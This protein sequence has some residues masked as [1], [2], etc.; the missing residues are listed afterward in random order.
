MT[1]DT[2]ATDLC[3]AQTIAPGDELRTVVSLEDGT[4]VS[5]DSGQRV[6]FPNLSPTELGLGDGDSIGLQF[7]VRKPIYGT[8]DSIDSV[9]V[10]DVE[11]IAPEAVAGD[12]TDDRS[13]EEDSSS[14]SESTQRV[15]RD[16]K[17]PDSSTNPEMMRDLVQGTL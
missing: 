2:T 3:E 17:R 16:R 1:S 5:S 12:R 6:T 9:F 14:T 10:D 8:D 11:T 13:R 15:G 4:I 7:V